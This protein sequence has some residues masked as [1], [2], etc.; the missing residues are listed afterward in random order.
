MGRYENLL[1]M[2]DTWLLDRPTMDAENSVAQLLDLLDDEVSEAKEDLD[3]EYLARELADI[4]VFLFSLFRAIGVDPY[5]AISEKMAL[6]L[7]RYHWQLFQKGDY[8]RART[9]VKRYEGEVIDEF[10][11]EE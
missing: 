1:S 7:L 9:V 11:R 2:T 6:N 4:G 10:Y 3:P 8:D 5:E